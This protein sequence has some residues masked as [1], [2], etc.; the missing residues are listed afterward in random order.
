MAKGQSDRGAVKG[1]SKARIA[2][3]HPGMGL[4]GSES[5]VL[6]TLQALKDDY[7]VTLITTGE[8]DLA[9]LNAYYGTR[10]A[11]ADLAVQYAPMPIGLRSTEKLVGLKGSFFQRYVRR[12]AADFNVMISCY[13][14]MDFG[15]RGI[16][17]IADFAFVDELRFSLHPGVRSWKQWW[18][19]RSPLRQLYLYICGIVNGASPGGWKRNLNL[20]NSDW[21]ARLLRDR[22]GV[23]SQTLYPPVENDFPQ[24]DS[25]KRDNGFVCLGRI[26]AEKR[27]DSII[28]ILSRVRQRGN[29]IHLHVLG[30]VDDSPYGARV[31]S[32]AERNREWIFLEGWAIGDEKKK[33]L[34]S[35]R[36][37][38]HG[39]E[40]EP[41]GI[42]VGEMV[43]AGCI[44]FVPNGGGQ[45][46]IVDHPALVFRDDA[47][48]VDKI[49]AVLKSSAEQEKLS[50][51]LR[52]SASRF[53]PGAFQAQIHQVVSEFL[54][55]QAADSPQRR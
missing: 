17:M 28:E 4:G 5:P 50:H 45:V 15:R 33:L 2:V 37:G 54:K 12:V 39:R 18:Y 34:A 16:Q 27:V 35:H 51:H 31:R 44:V 3:V 13:G 8:V 11:P 43:N 30:G 25:A 1:M 36:Y 19:G 55:E 40:N 52:Q 10:L 9:R 46:E 29:D 23:E 49:D 22:F 21:S 6:W 24:I 53:T 14:P 47:D 32:L 38:I 26:S 20:A 42:A 41:F 48:A 7:D